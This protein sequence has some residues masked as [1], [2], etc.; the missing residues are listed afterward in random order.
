AT[1]DTVTVTAAV[2]TTARKQLQVQAS[3][4]ATTATLQ[5]FVTSTDTLIGTL[6]KKGTRYTGKFSWPTNPVNITVKSSA[7]GTA[8]KAVLAR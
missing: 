3:T 5:V 7:G 4:T 1:T 2:Y 6:T 8:S